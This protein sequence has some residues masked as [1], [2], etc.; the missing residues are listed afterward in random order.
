MAGA[1][2]HVAGLLT[3]LVVADG[4]ASSNDRAKPAQRAKSSARAEV[5]AAL[6]KGAGP[7]ELQRWAA[8]EDGT[9]MTLA[10]DRD[11]NETVRA[12]ALAALAYA[13]NGRAHAF[14][15]NFVIEKTPSSDRLDRLLVRRAAVSLGWQGGPRVVEVLSPL[16][17]SAD[18]D[19]RLDAA[20]ALGLTRAREAEAPLRARLA[21]E[22]D[23]GVKRQLESAVK[24]VT[25][26]R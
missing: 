20:A 18:P 1:I 26:P 14:L 5:E 24:A 10:A 7:A 11:A 23:A 6:A 4:G 3:A 17:E 8:T 9:L 25:G 16:L 2:I 19:V 12:R 21:V 22:T 15:E 13:R